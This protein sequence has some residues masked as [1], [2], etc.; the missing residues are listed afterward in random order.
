MMCLDYASFS[1]KEP[2]SQS[3]PSSRAFS[4]RRSTP[5]SATEHRLSRKNIHSLRC[6]SFHSHFVEPPNSSWVRRTCV[7][8]PTPRNSTVTRLSTDVVSSHTKRSS[9]FGSRSMT[10]PVTFPCCPQLKTKIPPGRMSAQIR[11]ASQLRS[12]SED[13]NSSNTFSGQART[14]R[15]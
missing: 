11:G 3:H 1:K 7:L 14:M 9:L 10:S 8:M 6:P 4:I 13:E 12:P 15:S 5:T 2:R